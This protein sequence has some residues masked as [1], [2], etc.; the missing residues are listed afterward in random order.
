MPISVIIKAEAQFRTL[1]MFVK[2][3]GIS[4]PH[5]RRGRTVRG[6]T[7]SQ[8]RV[9]AK[10]I[11]HP[12]PQFASSETFPMF[13]TSIFV[14]HQCLKYLFGAVEIIDL[15]K[16]ITY[17]TSVINK[18]TTFISVQNYH[19]DSVTRLPLNITLYI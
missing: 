4:F 3:N 19:N 12:A 7:D 11:N 5:P 9:T 18:Q 2:I 17:K 10:V 8:T 1:G 14:E 6:G 13:T 15:T 16:N